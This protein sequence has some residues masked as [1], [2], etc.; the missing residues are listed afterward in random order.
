MED[1]YQKV[2]Y[3]IRDEYNF[4]HN[5][6]SDMNEIFKKGSGRASW[7]V[8]GKLIAKPRFAEL[9]SMSVV[10]EIDFNDLSNSVV[11]FSVTSYDKLFNNSDVKLYVEYQTEID[12]NKTTS[13]EKL[14]TPKQFD[15]KVIF[16]SN[17]ISLQTNGLNEMFRIKSTPIL[18]YNNKQIKYDTLTVTKTIYNNI[19]RSYQ[20]GDAVFQ[21][22]INTG[23]NPSFDL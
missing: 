23:D 12:A 14:L 17:N 4:D 8:S 13:I 19:E 15:N 1:D 21:Y 11:S 22:Q 10:P 5:V 20:I 16:E 9:N 7:L 18:K 3:F 2:E 6:T